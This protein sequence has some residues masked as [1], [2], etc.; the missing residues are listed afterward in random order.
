MATK[1][2]KI[3]IFNK[4]FRMNFQIAPVASILNRFSQKRSHFKA[5]DF[6][7][8][9]IYKSWF[10]QFAHLILRIILY[11]HSEKTTGIDH[12]AVLPD[13][14]KKHWRSIHSKTVSMSACDYAVTNKLG[15]IDFYNVIHI[16]W[17][18]TLKK[19]IANTNLC[20]Q[21]VW[22]V[23]KRKKGKDKHAR[24]I[25]GGKC[26]GHKETFKEI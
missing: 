20:N 22:M 8:S 11:S 14:D 3:F 7:F 19:K 2:H 17:R 16:K 6:L 12:I 18:Q 24:T 13:I 23:P 9:N 26:K 25:S 10:A 21:S 15:T 5:E 4:I 1:F